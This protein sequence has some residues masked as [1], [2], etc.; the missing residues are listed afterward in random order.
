MNT[1]RDN[2]R[3]NFVIPLNNVTRYLCQRGAILFV[4]STD[5]PADT[6]YTTGVRQATFANRSVKRSFTKTGTRKYAYFVNRPIR[7]I[8]FLL[9]LLIYSAL[10][11]HFVSFI[12]EVVVY[13]WGQFSRIDST[14]NENIDRGLF[15]YLLEL[16]ETR[17]REKEKRWPIFFYDFKALTNIFPIYIAQISSFCLL[18]KISVQ[19]FLR[20]IRILE[21]SILKGLGRIS[22]KKLSA[23]CVGSCNN[24]D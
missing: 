6:Y 12:R 16:D 4:V 19:F 21:N 10:F 22:R 5:I 8:Q 1:E 2:S 18:R 9:L 20:W 3:C 7:I 13:S 11:S 24:E 23:G 14:R 15:I 17:W